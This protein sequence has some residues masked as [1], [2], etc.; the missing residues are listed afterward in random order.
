MLGA[1]CCSPCVPCGLDGDHHGLHFGALGL[2]GSL[3]GRLWVAC[4][5]HWVRQGAQMSYL[6]LLCRRERQ[7]E[8]SGGPKGSMWGLEVCR[9]E[10][11]CGPL[12]TPAGASCGPYRR[13]LV[14]QILHHPAWA[15]AG[16]SHP[17]LL[18]L[19]PCCLGLDVERHC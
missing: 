1:P 11:P 14:D 8:G 18:G 19:K 5:L 7:L 17:E 16:M 10:M 4:G 15:A 2:I 12:W 9:P 3:L 6:S 13:I